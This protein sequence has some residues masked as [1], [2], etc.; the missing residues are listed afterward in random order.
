MD[1]E[2]MNV[3]PIEEEVNSA[4]VCSEDEELSV[5]NCENDE[6]VTV[7]EADDCEE[8][9]EQDGDCSYKCRIARKCLEVK[10]ACQ[11]T[12]ARLIEDWKETDG[13]PYVKQT[14]ITQVEIFR[15]P[16]DETPIDVFRTER[17][18]TYSSRAMAIVG[19]A[20][21]AVVCTVDQIT[22]RLLK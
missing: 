22:K 12:A 17:I 9:E 1:T 20:A 10:E 5:C 19:A 14:R 7:Y 11:Y 2:N 6:T 4:T 18:K 21:F 3:L 15:N 8:C 16:E 13:H